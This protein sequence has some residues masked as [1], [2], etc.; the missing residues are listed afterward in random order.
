MTEFPDAEP[1]EVGP[2]TVLPPVVS[3]QQALE[4]TVPAVTV[5]PPS[6]LAPL[7]WGKGDPPASIT[8]KWCKVYTYT[9][10]D[11]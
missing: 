5:V 10:G 9:Q 1:M 6:T 8:G 3:E 4:T 7:L 11:Y 2:H